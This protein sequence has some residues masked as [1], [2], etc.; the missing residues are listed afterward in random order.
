[1]PV[2]KS[3]NIKNRNKR[4]RNEKNKFQRIVKKSKNTNI[5]KL[6]INVFYNSI[7]DPKNVDNHNAKTFFKILDELIITVDRVILCF[8]TYGSMLNH[9]NISK[10]LL[11][12]SELAIF[13]SF[14]EF[15]SY[16]LIF[17]QSY[18]TLSNTIIDRIEFNG[19]LYTNNF[20]DDYHFA[21][22][23]FLKKSVFYINRFDVHLMEN[24]PP[25]YWDI[26]INLFKDTIKSSEKLFSRFHNIIK[27][28]LVNLSEISEFKVVNKNDVYC[29]PRVLLDLDGFKGIG[30]DLSIE[31]LESNNIVYFYEF[32]SKICEKYENLSIPSC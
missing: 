5:E 27:L 16:N 2:K 31:S 17:L 32:M 13:D 15:I 25:D 11:L 1:M 7:L 18:G 6:F 24:F 10:E 19:Y 8:S 20:Y 22:G 4:K 26:F 9:T 28:N 30:N 12:R 21:N 23:L 29:A 3:I 14:F